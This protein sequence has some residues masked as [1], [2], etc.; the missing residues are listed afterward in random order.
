MIPRILSCSLLTALFPLFPALTA[1]AAPIKVAT[2]TT[3]VSDLVRNVGGDRVVVDGLMGPGVDPHLYKPA[4]TDVVKL[5]GATVIFYSGLMLEGRMADLFARMGRQGKKVYAVTESIPREKLL[6]PEAFEGHWDPH[7]WGDP[8]L[9]SLCIE[10]VVNGLSDADPEGRAHYAKRGE[11][12]KEE[13]R[14]LH[15]WALDRVAGIPKD[16]RILI[17]SH[18]AFN[19]FGNAYGFRVVGLQGISTVGEAG[20]ADMVKMVDFIRQHGVKAVFVESSVPP[21]AMHRIRDDAGVRIGGEL[22]S[23]A[24]GAPGHMETAAGETY[25]AGTYTGMIKHNVNTIVEALK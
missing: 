20:G 1:N 24:M 5:S 2:T 7:V 23:D 25:D 15:E 11:A 14:E 9:W 16:Q 3:M 17:T 13:L 10:T 19:Y 6:E 21:A 18:D 12:F 4:A 22:F 8:M